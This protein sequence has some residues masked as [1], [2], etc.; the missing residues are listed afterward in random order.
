MQ[1]KTLLPPLRIALGDGSDFYESIFDL[2][3][4]QGFSLTSVE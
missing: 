1:V 2:N 3:L 4:E